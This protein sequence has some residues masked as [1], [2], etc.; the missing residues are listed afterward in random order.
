MTDTVRISLCILWEGEL[1]IAAKA[2]QSAFAHIDGDTEEARSQRYRD[3]L[4]ASHVALHGLTDE[5]ICVMVGS[6]QI[7]KRKKR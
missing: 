3:A 2:L 1:R 6:D 7:R 4:L 5:K